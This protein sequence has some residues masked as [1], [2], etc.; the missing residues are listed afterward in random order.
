MTVVVGWDEA[1][2]MYVFT[3][4]IQMTQKVVTSLESILLLLL[5]FKY[6]KHLNSP[7]TLFAQNFFGE[8]GIR[9]AVGADLCGTRMKVE[10]YITR[11]DEGGLGKKC[12]ENVNSASV[13][14]G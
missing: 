5:F 3:A 10:T 2:L 6:D 9:E 11:D 7:P 1:C 13:S 4:K 12:I 8:K 14:N